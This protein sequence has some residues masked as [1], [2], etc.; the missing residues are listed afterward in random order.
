MLVDALSYI[1][2][3]SFG[4]ILFYYF[5]FFIRLWGHKNT[6]QSND[7]KVS[8]IVCSRN[9][10]DNLE[11]NLKSI[12]QQKYLDFE[13]LLIDDGS[14][15]GGELYMSQLAEDYEFIHYHRLDIDKK[16][17]PGK[18]YA[19]QYGVE[20]ANNEI[21]LVTDADCQAVSD[22]WIEHMIG[23]FDE[24]TD[25]VIGYGPYYKKQGWFNAMARYE[26]VYTAIK[27]LSFAKAEI[28]YM[29][30]GRNMAYR[31]QVFIDNKGFESHIHIPSGDDDLFVREIAKKGNVKVQTHPDSFMWSAS[32]ENF[33][34][35]VRQKHRHLSVGFYY[36]P[37]LKFLLGMDLMSIYMFHMSMLI[38]LFMNELTLLVICLFFSKMIIQSIVF[39]KIYRQFKL[40][41]GILTTPIVDFL[42]IISYFYISMKVLIKNT[43]IWR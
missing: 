41:L 5:Y 24:Q 37:M 36:K 25:L 22:Q 38:L 16:K 3:S 6:F 34:L 30:V 23:S 8:V 4:V 13:L 32:A 1:L 14:T 9:E 11:Q 19:L 39:G 35:F 40:Q 42:H 2:I 10:K 26:C 7:Y 17:Y 15:D 29:G 27:Y 43:V 21:I 12:I 20:Q 28:P 33:K 18:K 31:K